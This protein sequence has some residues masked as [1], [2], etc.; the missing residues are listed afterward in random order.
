MRTHL[1]DE[2]ELLVRIGALEREQLRV[3]NERAHAAAFV[4]RE[5]VLPAA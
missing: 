5:T 4:R 2:F 3:A 1:R